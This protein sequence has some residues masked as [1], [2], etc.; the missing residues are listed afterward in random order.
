MDTFPFMG[1][2]WLGLVNYSCYRFWFAVPIPVPST[3]DP[4]ICLSCDVLGLPQI[5]VLSGLFR[6]ILGVHIVCVVALAVFVPDYFPL[7]DLPA[8]RYCVENA[9]E[10]CPGGLQCVENAMF[11]QVCLHLCW[12]YCLELCHLFPIIVKC[13][14]Y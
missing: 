5:L 14:Q 3:S 2:A 8:G 4:S 9:S 10:E 12:G 1:P 6:Y 11:C 13:M 7:A